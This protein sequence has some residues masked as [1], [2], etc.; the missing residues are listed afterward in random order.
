MHRKLILAALAAAATGLAFACAKA[1]SDD[2]TDDGGSRDGPIMDPACP[3]YDLSKDPKHCG[4]CTKACNGAQICVDG[5]CKAECD[6]PTTKCAG[7]AGGCFD[8]TSDPQHFVR[9]A[10]KC[11]QGDPDAAGLVPGNGN[12]DSGIPMDGGSAWTL[13]MTTCAMSKC[14]IDCPKSP[15][16]FTLCSDNICYDTKNFHERCG[17]CNTACQ[18]T[19][20]CT[21]GKC[22]TLGQS[23]CN[24][25]CIDTLTDKNNCGGCGTVCPNN[26]PNCINGTCSNAYTYTDNFVNGQSANAQCTH[27]QQWISGLANS[28]SAMT[29][30]GTNDSVGITCNNA[31]ITT[32]MAAA[33]KNVTA[34]TATCNGHVWS[35]CNRYN[36]ELWLDPPSQCSGN[37]CPSPGYIMRACIG[38]GNPN[39]G[40]IKTATC[41][42]PNQ[43]M[44]LSF[45]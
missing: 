13:G 27:W 18:S 5:M 9:C 42:G 25:M 2:V 36:D 7:D 21:Q 34:Y 37:N 35:N 32:L 12:P 43:T 1:S 29:I 10:T 20:W 6:P 33:L 26:K 3:Q 28:Y 45:F 16:V 17:D 30:S 24:G 4:A 44:T 22:C 8:F 41:G 40:G 14:G 19:E 11:P 31:Q 23:F 39:W 38:N 15:V